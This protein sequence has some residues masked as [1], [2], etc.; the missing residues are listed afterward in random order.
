ML[1]SFY[2]SGWFLLASYSILLQRS[3][4]LACFRFN[5]VAACQC[6][7]T[8]QTV[9]IRCTCEQEAAPSLLLA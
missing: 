3:C 1:E 5:L 2:V 4:S 6:H 7:Y 8:A 9:L